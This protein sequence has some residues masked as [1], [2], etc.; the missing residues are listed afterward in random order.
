MLGLFEIWNPYFFGKI[1]RT[2][3]YDIKYLNNLDV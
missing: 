3:I 1:K 2:C